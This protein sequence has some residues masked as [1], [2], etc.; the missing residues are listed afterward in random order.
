MAACSCYAASS[1]AL[2]LVNKALFSN[3]QFDYPWS[4][5][6]SQ[7]LGTVVCLTAYSFMRP[8]AKEALGLDLQ[9]LRAMAPV[10]LLFAAMLGSSSRALRY[11]SVPVVTIFKNI[12]VALITLYEWQVYSQPVSRGIAISLLSMIGG[13]I[14]AGA[15]DMQFSVVGYGWLFLNVA[16]TVAHLAGIRAWL[17]A[18]A[19]AAAKTLHNQLLAFVLFFS[20]AAASGEL[21]TFPSGL[22]AQS[23]TFKCGFLLSI[24]LGLSI[25]VASF[26]CLSVTSATTYS[27]VGASNKIPVAVLGHFLFSSGLTRIGWIGVIFG[28]LAGFGYAWSKAQ[29]DRVKLKTDERSD[30]HQV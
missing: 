29:L 6:M 3:H 25:N 7:A 20:G 19:S 18:S 9:L 30:E 15:G 26:W 8:G 4:V 22:I 10:T 13:S 12:A 17:K 23:T 5:L 16:C 28:I 27:F 24:A 11:C 2:S 21:R 14:V 1:V